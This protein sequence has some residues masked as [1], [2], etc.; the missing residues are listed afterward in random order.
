MFLRASAILYYLL[1]IVREHEKI[2]ILY[3]RTLR[4]INLLFKGLVFVVLYGGTIVKI[5]IVDHES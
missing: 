3:K 5:L 4:R 1:L 2:I